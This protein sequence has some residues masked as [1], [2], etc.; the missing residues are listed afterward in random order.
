MSTITQLNPK[1]LW[2]L[3]NQLCEIPRPSKHEQQVVAFI[4]DFAKKQGLDYKKDKEGNVIIRKPATENMEGKPT[5]VL[6]SHVDMVPQKNNDKKHDFLTDPITPVVDGEWVRADKTTLGADNGIGVA[7]MLAVLEDKTL[8]HGPVEALFTTDEETGM[9]GAFALSE[10]FVNGKVLLN[11]DSEEDG[12]VCLGCAG[13]IDANIAFHYIEDH[14]P[15]KSVAYTVTVKGLAGGHSGIDIH[16]E[17]GNAIKILNRILWHASKDYGLRLASL[18]GG[19]LRN[20]IP[21]EAQAIV[22]V[23]EGIKDEF[24][25]FVSNKVDIIKKEMEFN[26]PDMVIGLIES[27][28][29]YTLICEDIHHKLLNAL[30]ACP[31]G[32]IRMSKTMPGIVE[33]STNLAHISMKEGVIEIQCLL[34]SAVD[35]AKRNLAN[36]IDSVFTLAGADVSFDGEYPGW[37][38]DHQSNIL[39]TVQKVFKEQ[40]GKEAVIEVIHAGLECGIIGAKYPGM[41]MISFGPTIS[42]AH[43]PDEKV[44]VPS[45]EKFWNILLGILASIN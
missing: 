31:N 19:S 40:N 43:S 14:V 44:Q 35:S 37:K 11:L 3:F 20:A 1:R 9:T 5:V 21:R 12:V 38:P 15:E 25:N 8:T 10:N 36:M 42:G 41:E 16:K 28:Q 29:P 17:R 32:V 18:E 39:K 33:T 30:Y 23:N 26:E 27:E 13:G 7:A 24:K 6:Q 34:R 4:E 45:V 22:V 2:Y